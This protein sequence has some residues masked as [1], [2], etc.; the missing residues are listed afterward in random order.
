MLIDNTFGYL[1][2]LSTIN[3]QLS[4]SLKN[5]T[6][7]KIHNIYMDCRTIKTGYMKEIKDDITK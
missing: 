1:E 6:V 2:R 4:Q 5:S 7:D 3:A